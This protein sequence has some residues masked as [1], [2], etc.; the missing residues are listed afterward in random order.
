MHLILERIILNHNIR[1]AHTLKIIQKYR[2]GINVE[3]IHLK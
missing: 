3:N 1:P 2:N